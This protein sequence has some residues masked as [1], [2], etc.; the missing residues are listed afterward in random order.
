MEQQQQRQPADKGKQPGAQG[1][2]QPL[3]LKDL[4]RLVRA[5]KSFVLLSTARGDGDAEAVAAGAKGFD[6]GSATDGHAAAQSSAHIVTEERV[7]A[8]ARDLDCD[9]ALLKMCFRHA[10]LEIR[11]QFSGAVQVIAGG[12]SDSK[13]SSTRPTAATQREEF[14][15]AQSKQRIDSPLL[16]VVAATRSGGASRDK[17][18]TGSGSAE[19]AFSAGGGSAK[20]ADA[21]EECSYEGESFEACED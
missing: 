18:G 17:K 10:L 14:A 1:E 15:S 21:D 20:L 12:G 13:S 7:A 2:H 19:G 5:W 9:A 8:L 6:L 11:A 3:T 4:H 16:S